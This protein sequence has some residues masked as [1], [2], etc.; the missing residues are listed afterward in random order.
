MNLEILKEKFNIEVIEA[1]NFIQKVHVGSQN[2]AAL[3]TFLKNNAQFD[4]DRLSMIVCVD[5]KDSLELIY[6]LYSTKANSQLRVSLII[7]REAPK[8]PSVVEIFRSAYFEECEIYDLFGVD[9][10]NNPNLKRLYM[11]KG[12]KGHPLRKDY[13]QDDER[14]V[15]NR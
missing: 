9:F 11:P 14:L 5:L 15:W 1:A 8:A 4:F 2:L 10:I 7:D 13:V 6:D 12:W 3:L